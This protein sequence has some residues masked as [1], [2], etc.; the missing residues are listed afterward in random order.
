MASSGRPTPSALAFLESL[1]ATPYSY[2][3][4]ALL[5]RMECAYPNGPRL[6]ESRRP[7]EDRVRIGQ[8]P[9][10]SFAPSSIS[11]FKRGQGDQPSRLGVLSLG[12]LGPNGPMPL[13]LTEYIRDR[14]INHGDH[15]LLNFVNAFQHR[16]LSLFYRAWA[17]AEPVA[18]LDRSDP[19]DPESNRFT[20]QVASLIGLGMASL[21]DRDAMPDYAKLF[22]SGRYASMTK[23]AEGLEAVLR[24]MLSLDVRIEPFTGKWITLGEDEICRLGQSPESGTLGRSIVVGDRAWQC[25][26]RFRVVL[27]PMNY[28]EYLELLP[29]NERV[30]LLA[31]TIRNYVGDELDWDVRL[32]LAKEDV[33]KLELGV[34]G[35]LGWTT[36]V[37]SDRPTKDM[38]KFVFE[39]LATQKEHRLVSEA[40]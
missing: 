39:P 14:V 30:E 8:D 9:S 36:L 21:R 37:T 22:L 6:G 32:V 7:R 31:A 28:S 33:P 15:T 25:H 26:H 5:R 18:H 3:F 38:D 16:L 23:N 29:G 1:E 34:Q 17:N 10:L 13:H 11:S 27:G 35:Q 40:S 20:M 24:T 19:K 12:L 2:G 4:Y